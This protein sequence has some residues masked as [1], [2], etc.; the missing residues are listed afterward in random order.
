MMMV[1]ILLIMMTVIIDCGDDGGGDD[2]VGGGH[3]PNQPISSINRCT[4]QE[5]LLLKAYHHILA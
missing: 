1:V 3:L 4:K 5:T 2:I